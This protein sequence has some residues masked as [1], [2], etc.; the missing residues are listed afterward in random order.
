MHLS[1]PRRFL[2]LAAIT[3][4]LLSTYT[5]SLANTQQIYP[6]SIQEKLTKLEASSGG[7]IGLYA[8]NT[9]NNAYI[10]YRPNERFPMC[11]TFKPMLVS[12]ILKQSMTDSH[13][14]Q[15]KVSYK[16]NDLMAYSPITKNHVVVGMTISELCAAAMLSDN[17]AAN[18]LMKKLGG[19][20]AV[21]AFA[22]SIGDSTFRVNRW[23]PELNTAI[24]GDLRDTSTPAAMEKSLQEVT[25]GDALALP[26]RK[27]LQGWFKSNTTGDSRIRAGVPKGWIVGDKTG[28]CAYG[29]TNDIGIIWP[30]KSPPIVIA[31]YFT[32]NKKD[33]APRDDVIATVTRI[34][35]SE[36]AHKAQ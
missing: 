28:T 30:P 3:I 26:L 36:F 8:V 29:T 19:P 27:Q 35:I 12:A 13:L 6:A 24:P 7:R 16:K 1:P 23:E 21:N 22:R 32:Q 14:L 33:A 25:L 34:I 5:A 20:E 2:L 10:Q 4:S 18:L 17:T 31:I 15:Q 9:A 11:S